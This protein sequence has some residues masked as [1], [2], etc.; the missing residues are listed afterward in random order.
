MIQIDGHRCKVYIKFSSTTRMQQVLK[1]TQGGLEY[2]HD[3]DEISQIRIELAGMGLKKVR[4]ANLPPE[5]PDRTV[6]DT[7]AQYE[8]ERVITE[9]QWPKACIYWVSNGVR[10]V[11]M[12]LRKHLPSHMN[13]A[14]NRVLVAYE[15]QPSTCNGCGET[16]QQYHDCPQR[17]PKPSNDEVPSNTTWA[18]IFTLPAT[19]TGPSVM[20]ETPTY[21]TDAGLRAIPDEMTRDKHVRQVQGNSHQQLG[22]DQIHGKE[23]SLEGGLQRKIQSVQRETRW[24]D[25]TEIPLGEKVQDK[26]EPNELH[27]HT[28][29]SEHSALHPYGKSGE[30]VDSG[31]CTLDME[32]DSPNPPDEDSQQ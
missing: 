23:T 29:Y 14:G 22:Q 7:L 10:I 31:D 4:I 32:A 24:M 8:E 26:N 18:D 25:T 13:I 19:K 6:R 17:K 27:T 11:E 3:N 21:D 12:S 16:G 2:Q 28:R 15:G 20:M 1:E 30:E 9:E 5:V